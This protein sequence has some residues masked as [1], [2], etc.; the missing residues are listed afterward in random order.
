[1]ALGT[2]MNALSMGL[3]IAATVYIALYLVL[4]LLWPFA[5]VCGVVLGLIWLARIPH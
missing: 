5:A 3:R 1:L 4:V 2:L